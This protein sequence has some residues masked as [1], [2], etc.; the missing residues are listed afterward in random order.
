MIVHL[1]TLVFSAK[2]TAYSIKSNSG[3]Y[4]SFKACHI[5][6]N[7]WYP[8][9]ETKNNTSVSVFVDFLT[10]Y[11]PTKE[12]APSITKTHHTTQIPLKLV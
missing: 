8:G 5:S 4:E 7:V 3:D 9:W 6:E 11:Q 1:L 12:T 10:P 2:Q